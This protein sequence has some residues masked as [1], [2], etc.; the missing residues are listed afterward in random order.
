M[1]QHSVHFRKDGSPTRFACSGVE[2]SKSAAIARARR[3]LRQYGKGE[4]DTVHV[5]DDV[6]DVEVWSRRIN[7]R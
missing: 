3:E 1:R 5:V 4:F 7:G 6:E 2:W